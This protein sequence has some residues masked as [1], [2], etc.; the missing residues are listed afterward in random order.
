MILDIVHK[1]GY[2]EDVV[3]EIRTFAMIADSAL[4][5]E[6]FDCAYETSQRMISIVLQLRE[7]TSSEDPKT[8]EATEVCW[9]A[10]YTLG[11]QIELPDTS[12]KCTLLARALELCPPDR[13]HDILVAWK[14]FEGDEIKERKTRLTQRS[15][16]QS[17]PNHKATLKESSLLPMSLSLQ[18][19]LSDFHM[20]S[21]PLL[22][23]PDAAALATRTFKN[24]AANFPFRGR[25]RVSASDASEQRSPSGSR[26]GFD[27][28][29]AGRVLSRGIGW[30]IG[31]D[32]ET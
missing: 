32:E 19:K 20:P 13:L 5:A 16:I 31:A 30:L 27:G 7:S 29:D 28:S 24:V 23:T 9:V 2:R 11:R 18:S 22:S 14:K 8:V 10:C 17:A 26:R 21:P 6:D 1:L 4:Q 3:A 15:A 25:S 12:R